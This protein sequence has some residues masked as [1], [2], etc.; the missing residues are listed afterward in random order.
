MVRIV[1]GLNADQCGLGSSAN[2][3]VE[4]SHVHVGFQ[5]FANYTSTRLG[6]T[7]HYFNAFD[8]IGPGSESDAAVAAYNNIMALRSQ[9][10]QEWRIGREWAFSY[11]QRGLNPSL[12]HW[13]L[14]E[15][16]CMLT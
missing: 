12:R 4:F 5:I 16:S 13:N 8:T 2:S 15:K 3:I 1:P 6:D 14:R 7:F 10:P 9:I 11:S